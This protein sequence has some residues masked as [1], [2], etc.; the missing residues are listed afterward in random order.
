MPIEVRREQALDAALQLIAESGY[1]SITMEAIARRARLAKPVL[2][3]AYPGLGP[4]LAAL[5][6]REQQRGLQALAAAMPPHPVE[7]DPA[8]LLLSWLSTLAEVIAADPRPWRLILVPPDETPEVVRARVEAGRAF[9]LTQ[10]HAAVGAMLDR[11]RASKLDSELT[12]EMVLAMAEH[13]AKLLIDDPAR[14]PPER[15]VGYARSL[16]GA[17]TT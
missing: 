12:A 4:L 17:L 11:P 5:L 14:Y 9:A 6:E 2:Y 15:L 3:N 10:I 7:S 8:A 13:G 16:L 1:G